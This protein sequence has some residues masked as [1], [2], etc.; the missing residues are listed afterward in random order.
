M[1]TMTG[2]QFLLPLVVLGWQAGGGQP[3]LPPQR[4]HGATLFVEYDA[5]SGEAI[6]HAEADSDAQL[7]RFELRDPSDHVVVEL[8]TDSGHSAAR[9]ASTGRVASRPSLIGFA[10]ELSEPSLDAL[11]A[12]HPEGMYGFRGWTADGRSLIGEARLSHSL[13]VAPVVVYP[14]PGS[15]DSPLAGDGVLWRSDP[16]AKGYTVHL[17]QGEDR[18]LSVELPAGSSSFR[19]PAGWLVPGTP[20]QLEVGVVGR[21]ANCTLVTVEFT[22]AG[23]PPRH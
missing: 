5:T 14:L 6:L 4:F 21:N 23:A 10:T 7:V 22:T 18:A 19:I 8:R 9:R 20:T 15:V 1:H 17:E 13:L 2:A 3:T 12:A 16:R 11:C